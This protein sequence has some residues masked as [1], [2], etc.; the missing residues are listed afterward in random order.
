MVGI[1]KA[2]ESNWLHKKY[3]SLH[4]A[5]LN[6]ICSLN[7]GKDLKFVVCSC[8][9]IFIRSLNSCGSQIL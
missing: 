1:F 6:S 9:Y 3:F 4:L 8:G 2:G 5:I 7:C